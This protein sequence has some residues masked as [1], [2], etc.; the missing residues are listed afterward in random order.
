MKFFKKKDEEPDTVI[1]EVQLSTIFR[2]YLYDTDLTDDINSL[3]E[4]VGLS[5]ISEEVEDKELEASEKRISKMA[6]LFV[7]LDTI[8]EVNARAVSALHMSEMLERQSDIPENDLEEF[9]ET[10]FNIY[11]AISL[12][13]LIGAFSVGIELGVIN[14]SVVES[15]IHPGL[16]EGLDNE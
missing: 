12:S 11:K 8:S 15:D 9:A 1:N 10:S 6:N 14:S 4:M 2:W 5:R 3:A 13:A 7:Y 16:D